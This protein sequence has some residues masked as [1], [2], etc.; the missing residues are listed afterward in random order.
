MGNNANSHELLSVVTAV[1]HQGVGE[2]LDDW[3][4]CLTESLLCV[5]TG[6]MGD[7]DGGADLDIIAVVVLAVPHSR[8]PFLLTP[9]PC[10]FESKNGLSYVKEIS[11]ISTSSYDLYT[12]NQ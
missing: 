2:T 8:S 1:H 4:L 12:G 10:I 9:I 7:V 6:G 11:R 5:T 3:A